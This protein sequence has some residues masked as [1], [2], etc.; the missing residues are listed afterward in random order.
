MKTKEIKRYNLPVDRTIIKRIDAKPYELLAILVFIALVISLNDHWYFG[1]G[2]AFFGILIF[3]VMP[4]RLLIEFTDEYLVLYN[5]VNSADCMIVYYD[6]V[7]SW[8]YNVGFK[9]DELI[10]TLSDGSTQK[11]EAFSK[12]T[13]ELAMN[14]F[15]KDKKDKK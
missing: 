7:V 6:D 1:G 10:I 4:N 8:R 12:L 9:E 3:V 11:I 13:F 2:F 5:H 15:L 14:K